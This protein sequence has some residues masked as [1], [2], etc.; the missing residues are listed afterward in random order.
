MRISIKVNEEIWNEFE[1]ARKKWGY[2]KNKLINE[3]LVFSLHIALAQ[4]TVFQTKYG[5]SL[6]KAGKIFQK[7]INEPDIQKRIWDKI[8]LEVSKKEYQELEAEEGIFDKRSRKL[9]KKPKLGRRPTK[10]KRKRPG[11]PKKSDISN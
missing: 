11:H 1:K 2:S 8:N 4:E 9:L 3:C 6:N 10:K 5:K 7:V